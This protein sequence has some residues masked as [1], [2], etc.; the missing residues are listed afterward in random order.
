MPT[1]A[2]EKPTVESDELYKKGLA[3]LESG[4]L[5]QAGSLL[6]TVINTNP[7]NSSAHNALGKV[8]QKRDQLSSSTAAYCSAAVLS[9]QLNSTIIDLAT[10]YERQ[11]NYS[12]AQA[13]YKK[14][15]QESIDKHKSLMG[16]A[17]INAIKGNWEDALKQMKEADS[18]LPNNASINYNM[19]ILSQAGAVGFK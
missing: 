7:Q 18:L 10:S 14:A 2:H 15:L 9:S 13:L 3:L 8:L 12:Q 4:A 16:L 19:A 17:R 1:K 6:R 11:K 5:I